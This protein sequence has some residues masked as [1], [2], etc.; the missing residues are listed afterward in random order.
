MVNALT[1]WFNECLT[2]EWNNITSDDER[3]DFLDKF[4]NGDNLASQSYI[5]SVLQDYCSDIVE[6]YG[7]NSNQSSFCKAILDSLD[8]DFLYKQV[9]YFYNEFKDDIESSKDEES[10]SS[11]DDDSDDE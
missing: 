10:S 6:M 3:S 5:E 1:D 11:S 9:E 7:L 2:D 8:Y 4:S